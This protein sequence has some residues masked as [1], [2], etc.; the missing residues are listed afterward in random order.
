MSGERC[1]V[2]MRRV[3]VPPDRNMAV[4][5]RHAHIQLCGRPAEKDGLCRFHLRQLASPT[6]LSVARRV[7]QAL[8]RRLGR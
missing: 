3:P 8:G 7:T 5:N 1:D 2:L 4:A 6:D